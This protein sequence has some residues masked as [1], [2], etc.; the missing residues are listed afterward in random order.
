MRA[1]KA[2][3]KP[4]LCRIVRAGEPTSDPRHGANSVLNRSRCFPLS[5]ETMFKF[6]EVLSDAE[7]EH[8]MTGLWHSMVLS[9]DHVVAR[10][11][12]E[13]VT[14]LD[15]GANLVLEI[16]ARFGEVGDDPFKHRIA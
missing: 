15:E 7:Q 11:K 14:S 4:V 13:A 9:L 8:S 5:K 2:R 3:Y 6:G 16:V 1:M 10:L 12:C